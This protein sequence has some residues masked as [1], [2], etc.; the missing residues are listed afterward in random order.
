MWEKYWLTET[1]KW[2]KVDSSY[3]YWCSPSAYPRN[4][5]WAHCSTMPRRSRPCSSPPPVYRRARSR[6]RAHWDNSQPQQARPP[7]RCTIPVAR[8]PQS[9]CIRYG[10]LSWPTMPG[11]SKWNRCSV[12]SCRLALFGTTHEISSHVRSSASPKREHYHEVA[13][14]FFRHR[15]LLRDWPHCPI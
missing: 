2:W 15:Y 10:H 12:V 9:R 6:S 5:R 7:R 3:D 8:S 11:R 4:R 1:S 14:R 13:S